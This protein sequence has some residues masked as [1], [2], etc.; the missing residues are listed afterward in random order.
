[1]LDDK[2]KGFIVVGENPAVGSANSG[3]HR[4]ALAE[5]DWLVVRDLVE[6]ETAAFW[7]DSP[8]IERGELRTEDIGTEVFFLPA[9]AHTEKDGSFTNTQRLLQWHHKAVEPTGDCRSELWFYY[10]LGRLIREKLAGSA[11][12]RDRPVLD[13]QWDYPTAGAIAEPSAEAVLREINGTG[14]DGGALSAYT[15]LKA[16]GSTACG[17]WIYCGCFA[18]ETNQPARRK[19]GSRAELGRAGVGLGLAGEPPHPLQPGLGR[20]R[21]PAVVGAQALRVVGRGRRAGGRARTCPTSSPTSGPTTSRPRARRPQDADRAATHPF[22]MQ[23]DGRG[24]LFAPTGLVDG[25]LPTHYEPHESPFRNPL[26]A[27]RS[28]PARQIFER[29]GN[30]SQPVR[31]RARRRRVSR[32]SFT[33]YRLTEHHTAGGMSRFVPYLSELQPEMFCEV[34]PELAAERGLEH[35]GWATIATE[36]RGDRGARARHRAHAAAAACRAGRCTRSACRTTGARAAS[37]RATR[38]TTCSR[39]CST[40]TCTSRRSRRRRATSAPAARPAG[41]CDDRSR[42]RAPR[43]GRTTYGGEAQPRMGFFT[44]TSVCIGCKACEVACK[45]WNQ[46]PEDGLLFT[47]DSLRQHRRRSARTPGGT[48]RSSSRS[49]RCASPR[50]ARARAR[51]TGSAG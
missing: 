13:L 10:H 23:A 3:L 25:P 19:P 29:P 43:P 22:I 28:N 37:A 34:S 41:R 38:P 5:L 46:V 45:E 47:G 32:T 1:M 8:E 48:S 51:A 15:E 7:Y 36:P 27:Q 35:G 24:W 44:D 12:E 33:T 30:R 49:G 20:P 14:P 2:V 50:A 6:I 40:P 31:R 21:R 16:D 17:C 11:D 4:K 42:A 9:A 18:G 39:S 26:Y